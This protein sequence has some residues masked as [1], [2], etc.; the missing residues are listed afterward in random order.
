MGWKA[1]PTSA[2]WHHVAVTYDGSVEKTYVDG[3]LSV[4]VATRYLNLWTGQPAFIGVAYD[5]STG[6]TKS[7]W[8]SAS[9]AS[10]Q[11]YDEALTQTEIQ[12]IGTVTISGQV[13]GPTGAGLPGAIVGFKDNAKTTGGLAVAAVADSDIYTVADYTGRYSVPV[14][15]GEVYYEAAWKDGYAPSSDTSVTAD[16]TKVVN[17]SVASEAGVNLALGKTT[18]ATQLWASSTGLGSN[19]VNYGFDGDVTSYF[20]WNTSSQK[21][22]VVDVSKAGGIADSINGVTVITSS[23]RIYDWEIWTENNAAPISG[24]TRNTSANWTRMYASTGSFGGFDRTAVNGEVVDA[25]KMATTSARGV[26]VKIIKGSSN[27]TRP[28]EVM[29]TLQQRPRLHRHYQGARGWNRRCR[30]RQRCGLGSQRRQRSPHNHLLLHGRSGGNSGNPGSG[31]SQHSGRSESQRLDIRCRHDGHGHDHWRALPERFDPSRG[32][33]RNWFGP[34]NDEY[35]D[36][37]DRFHSDRQTGLGDGHGEAGC[38]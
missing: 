36:S 29:V 14:V 11:V 27:D 15:K 34:D 4:S 7:Q 21:D 6:T 23:Y 19:P 2:A 30:V 9:M 8:F 33:R 1:L 12:A 31:S 13:T 28:L 16:V 22:V 38:R 37:L 24:G 26:W 3:I 10:L 25:V 35:A 5:N 18:Q 17:I 32:R 20:S